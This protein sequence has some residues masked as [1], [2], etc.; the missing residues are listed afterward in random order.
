[1]KPSDKFRI[2]EKEGMT[3]SYFDVTTI[4]QTYWEIIRTPDSKVIKTF[5][6]YLEALKYL[7]A[8]ED[9]SWLVS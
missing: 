6:D 8:L 7:E 4:P 1:M 9:R 2:V 3:Y 5:Y